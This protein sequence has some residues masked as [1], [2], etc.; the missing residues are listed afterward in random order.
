L[1]TV[2]NLDVEERVGARSVAVERIV[3]GRPGP[4]LDRWDGEG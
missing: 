3:L 1:T 4:E 2:V